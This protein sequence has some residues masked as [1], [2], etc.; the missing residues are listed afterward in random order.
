M[1]TTCTV[2]NR[3]LNDGD[4]DEQGVCVLCAE[5]GADDPNLADIP[6][7]GTE[8]VSARIEEQDGDGSAD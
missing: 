1:S 8:D 7:R 2:C 4:A 3:V 5:L 6:M